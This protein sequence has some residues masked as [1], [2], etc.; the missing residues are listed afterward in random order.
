L[1]GVL[2]KRLS[3]A[4][5]LRFSTV[6]DLPVVLEGCCEHAPIAI[7]MRVANIVVFIMRQSCNK[8]LGRNVIYVAKK[9][10]IL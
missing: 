5:V 6:T 7:K 4:A 2:F 3:N 8:F 10:S 1:A 9:M